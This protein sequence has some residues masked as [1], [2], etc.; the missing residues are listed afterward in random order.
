VGT[1]ETYFPTTD[2]KKI[3]RKYCWGIFGA[4]DKDLA[5]KYYQDVYDRK[6]LSRLPQI[7]VK[8]LDIEPEWMDRLLEYEVPPSK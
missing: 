3:N 8:T 7:K 4:L 5:L 6:M 2:F 1:I